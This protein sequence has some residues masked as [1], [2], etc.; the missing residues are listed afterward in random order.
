VQESSALETEG[1]GNAGCPKHPQPRVRMGVVS[2][3]LFYAMGFFARVAELAGSG[4]E[5]TVAA[6]FAAIRD[7]TRPRRERRK[8][9][10]RLSRFMDGKQI[11]ADASVWL[12]KGPQAGSALDVLRT[13][14]PCVPWQLALPRVSQGSEY[15]HFVFPSSE[16]PNCRAPNCRDA[17]FANLMLWRC[18]GSTEPHSGRP[19]TCQ[20]SA[21]LSEVIAPTPNYESA[22]QPLGWCSAA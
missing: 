15:V 2:N 11:R 3:H 16:I 8:V 14:D 20:T 4:D 7:E 17:G 6:E 19:T 18:G 12:Y 22:T 1:A 9:L 13:I 10:A 21:G 5:L